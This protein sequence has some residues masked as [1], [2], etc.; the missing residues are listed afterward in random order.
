MS[1]TPHPSTLH[2]VQDLTTMNLGGSDSPI[3]QAVEVIKVMAKHTPPLPTLVEGPGSDLTKVR[4]GCGKVV[5]DDQ[6]KII[7]TG[8]INALDGICPSC[9]P[10]FKGTARLVCCA[11]K[12]VV[13]RM[14]PHDA[15]GFK[16]VADK[17]YHIDRCAY[18]D[19]SVESATIIELACWNNKKAGA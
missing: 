10:T 11:C 14:V 17:C 8:V 1:D 15:N 6:V 16:F 12:S 18:C 7:N 13:G 4:C 3:E 19:P 9:E 5:P 2:L